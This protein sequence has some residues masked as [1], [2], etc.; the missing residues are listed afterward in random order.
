MPDLRLVPN[1][2]SPGTENPAPEP[3]AKLYRVRLLNRAGRMVRKWKVAEWEWLD[4]DW[5]I[6]A[7]LP[8][9][10]EAW[11]VTNGLT[12]VIEEW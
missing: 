11:I 9:G 6:H 8:D 1:P 12:L 4:E 3:E 2:D 5:G 10:S 7:T